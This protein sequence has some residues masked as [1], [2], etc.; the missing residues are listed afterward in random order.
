[1]NEGRPK[2]LSILTEN[3]DKIQSEIQV[4]YLFSS[5]SLFTIKAFAQKTVAI[6]VIQF[7]YKSKKLLSNQLRF[8]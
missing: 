7:T 3:L 6:Q 2:G 5:L 4:G 8:S 1:M